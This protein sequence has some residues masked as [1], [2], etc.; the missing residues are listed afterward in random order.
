MKV[1]QLVALSLLTAASLGHAQMSPEMKMPMPTKGSAS[2]V[3]A[4]MVMTDGVVQGVDASKGVVTLKHGDITNMQ[5]PAMTMAFGVADKRMLDKVKPGDKV[6][7]HLEMLK[8][9]PT[10]THIEQTK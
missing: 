7:F 2:A 10:V 8:N 1:L 4:S 3:S 6:K 5:M 9:A